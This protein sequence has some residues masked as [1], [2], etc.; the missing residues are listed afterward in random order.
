MISLQNVATDQKSVSYSQLTVHVAA[1]RVAV[2]SL[3]SMHDVTG[4]NTGDGKNAL[5]EQEVKDSY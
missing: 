2:I 1:W 4:S 3:G 5:Q